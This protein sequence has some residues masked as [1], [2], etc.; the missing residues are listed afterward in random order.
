MPGRSL[1]KAKPY[2]LKVED[3]FVR[4]AEG[5]TGLQNVLVIMVARFIQHKSRE[6]KVLIDLVDRS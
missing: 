1:S 5:G 6:K 2:R 3:K 4:T